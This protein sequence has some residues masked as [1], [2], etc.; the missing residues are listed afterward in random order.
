MLFLRGFTLIISITIT[1]KRAHK[2][3]YY[4]YPH[5]IAQCE[6]A[7][8]SA[9]GISQVSVQLGLCLLFICRVVIS[10]NAFAYIARVRSAIFQALLINKAK[11]RRSSLASPASIA[12]ASQCEPGLRAGVLSIP[13]HGGLTS[14]VAFTCPPSA[15]ALLTA[16][17]RNMI[18]TQVL[19]VETQRASWET[20]V[21]ASSCSHMTSVSWGVGK[22]SKGTVP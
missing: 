19:L 9:R 12:A 13:Y 11:V 6:W 20:G 2:D 14:W 17:E 10:R 8:D 22:E 4:C 5:V 21:W 7:R 16:R 18:R 1:I 3:F 15:V